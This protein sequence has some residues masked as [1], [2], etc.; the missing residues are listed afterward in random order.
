MTLRNEQKYRSWVEVDLDNFTANLR[1]I[2]RLI[3]GTVDFMQTVKA[4]A[5]GHGAIEISHAALREGAR[6]LGVAN[7]DEGIQLRISGIEAPIVI[8]GPSTLSEIPD[9]IKYNL[10]PSVSDVAFARALEEQLERSSRTLSVHVEVDTGMG[11]GGTMHS[12][13]VDLIGH[14]KTMRH[15]TLEGIF[16]HF[17]SSETVTAYNDQQWL[18]FSGL[19]AQLQQTGISIPVTHMDN[20]GAILNYPDQKL[21]MTRPGIMTYG[22]YPSSDTQNRAVLKPVMSFKTTIVLIKEFPKGYGIGYNR[23]YITRDKTRVATIPVGYGD[24]YP[25]IL[26]N[27]GEAL[28]RGRRAPVIG[29]VSMDMCTLD[30]THIPDCTVG[31]E[32]VL[33]GRQQNE[34]ISANEIA[35]KAQ[36]ISYEVLCALG[37]RAPRVFLQKGKT[38]A[39]EPRLRR[40]FVPDEEKSIARIDNII[41]HCFQTRTRNEELGD[42]IYYEMFETLFGKEDRQLEL[43]SCFRYDITISQLPEALEPRR[44]SDAYFQL[45][46]HVEYKKTIRSDIFMIGCASDQ[47][48]LDALIEDEHCEYRWILGGDDL[49]IE[50]DFTVEKM[51][52]DGEDIPIIEAKKTE[53]GY[54]VWC[55]SETLKPKINQEVK[56]EIE[57][58]TKKAKRNRTFPVYLLYPTRGL[59]INFRY[60]NANLKNVRAESFFAGRHPR[61][62]ISTSR[63]KSINIKI[64]HEE[65]VFPTSGVI[66]I[67]DV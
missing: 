47:G 44:R 36:T 16:S 39:V 35:A 32:V 24:G 61:A 34:Y 13:A 56:I 59:E 48:Q 14:I 8:L 40:I 37:K 23:T 3:G 19:L 29:R 64:S 58:L 51:R 67:W 17:A 12:E 21:Q 2:K 7:A 4:D 22:I 66:F 5:Y 60:E 65:W 63:G 25:F 45:R 38:D 11:R 55:G 54:E 28:I 52:I 42:A 10:T 20:S 62:A 50:R 33:L 30:V 6:M 57:I 49:V 46:T 15:L 9:V 1:E 31:D 41:R 18:L 27:R 43:R 53:R 26:S